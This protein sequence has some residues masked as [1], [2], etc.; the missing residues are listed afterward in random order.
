MFELGKVGLPMVVVGFAYMLFVGRLF[1]PKNESTELSTTDKTEKYLAEFIVT[2]DSA[3]IKRK[4][5]VQHLADNFEIELTEV[6]RA[7]TELILSENTDRYEA[8]D[9]LR[10]RGTLEHIFKLWSGGGLVFYRPSGQTTAK[11]NQIPE[12]AEIEK[13][14]RATFKDKGNLAEVVVLTTSGLIGRT[15]QEARFAERYDA[16]VLALRRRGAARG[17]PSTTPLH[18]GDV[19]VVE[20]TPEALKT[21]AETQGFLVIGDVPVPEQISGKILITL[22]TLFGVIALVISG[23]TPIV[24]AAVAGCAVLV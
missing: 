15:L 22:L 7:G 23:L 18:T 24:T 11:E 20:G 16:V 10:V 1:L 8:F 19:L 12:D 13:Q 3:W 6:F 4:I 9:S 2:E 5:D 17:R 14:P 21:L